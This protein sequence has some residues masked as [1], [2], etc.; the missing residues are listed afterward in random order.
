[1][2]R[3][4]SVLTVAVLLCPAGLAA[5]D[6]ALAATVFVHEDAA[7]KLAIIGSVAVVITGTDAFISRIMEDALAVSLLLQGIKVAYP[8]EKDLGKTR[9]R[10]SDATS[11]AADPLRLAKSVGANCLITGTLVTE[12]PSLDQLRPL[13]VAI[14]SLS[15]IDVPMDKTLVWALYEPEQTV[16]TTKIARAF[17]GTLVEKL[18]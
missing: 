12:P 3:L 1:M 5:K 13:R 11:D 17:A 4:V 6:D 7:G 16:T 18:K 8:D 9:T 14:A 15:L 10:P 2:N